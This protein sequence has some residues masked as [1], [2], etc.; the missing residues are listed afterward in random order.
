MFKKV[1]LVVVVSIMA[2][3]FLAVAAAG[4]AATAGLAT[5]AHVISESGVVQ[6]FE[7]VAEG[8]DTLQIEV[9]ENSVTFTNP[10]SG[11]SRTVT[12]NERFSSGRFQFY[13]PELTITDA[14]G[15][16]VVV[17]HGSRIEGDVTLPEIT[18]T[19]PDNG[20]SRVI[21]PNAERFDSSFRAPR[22]VW[23]GQEY[24][25]LT[26]LRIVG[27]FLRGLFSLAFLVLV[28]AVA[29]VLLRNRRREQEKVDVIKGDDA[30]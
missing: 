8:A 28:A 19:D 20:Q 15:E 4:V 29:Y 23:G 18:I 12:S 26:G 1:V 27:E 5:A 7:E 6:A 30:S 14:D 24:G 16:R 13:L 25:S 9:D 11:E 21:I 22:I 3:V 17:S 2:L 10:D